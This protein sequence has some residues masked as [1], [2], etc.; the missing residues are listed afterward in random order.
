[1]I[2]IDSNNTVWWSIGDERGS[3]RPINAEDL[4]DSLV[5]NNKQNVFLS[6]LVKIHPKAAF[7]NYVDV[8]DDFSMVEIALRSDTTFLERYL[9][10]NQA[11]LENFADTT[12]SYRYTTAP[13]NDRRDTRMLEISVDSMRTRGE[14]MP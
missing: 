13:W 1:V 7:H 4:I 10:D 12:Y 2:R 8:L 6:T 14:R 9:S 11:A 3:S 5:V